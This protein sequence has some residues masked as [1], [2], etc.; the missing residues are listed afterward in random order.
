VGDFI[1]LAADIQKPYE[2][3]IFIGEE[4]HVLNGYGE[5]TFG[6]CI[7]YLGNYTHGVT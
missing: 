7:S 4:D 5:I 6:I 2:L 1:A 3:H